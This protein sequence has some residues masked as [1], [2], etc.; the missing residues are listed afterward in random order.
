MKDARSKELCF[1]LIAVEMPIRSRR[2][3]QIR[4]NEGDKE[5]SKTSTEV[6]ISNVYKL[7]DAIQRWPLPNNIASMWVQYMAASRDLRPNK[8]SHTLTTA[9]CSIRPK[10]TRS[11]RIPGKTSCCHICSLYGTVRLVRQQSELSTHV[12][13][14]VDV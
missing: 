9:T 7:G 5:M 3:K 2:R 1:G 13:R 6:A 8:K 14:R 10:T 12:I 4:E 11:T